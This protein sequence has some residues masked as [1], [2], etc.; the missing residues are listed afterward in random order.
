M[1]LLAVVSAGPPSVLALVAAWY[2]GRHDT[3]ES[4]ALWAV[5]CLFL[6]LLL[7]LFGLPAGT[8]AQA[9]VAVIGDLLQG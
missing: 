3:F 5:G 8:R 7:A 1:R 2:G 4:L 9:G 6:T